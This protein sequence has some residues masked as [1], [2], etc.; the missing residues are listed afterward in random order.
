M[1]FGLLIIVLFLMLPGASNAQS[2]EGTVGYVGTPYATTPDLSFIDDVTRQGWFGDARI[3][4]TNSLSMEGQ[5]SGSYARIEAGRTVT[6][7]DL[8]FGPRL[9]LKDI[10]GVAPYGHLLM[11][12]THRNWVATTT[13]WSVSVGLGGGVV[14]YPKK[15]GQL[16]LDI[17]MDYKKRL[18]FG[19]SP[20]WQDVA[21]RIGVSFR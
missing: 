12:P 19:D 7:H 4:L 16:G 14:I 17:G 15:Q 5:L 11:G 3:L 1:K 21:L 13:G 6:I 9:V 18:Q 20:N 2:F 8:L 10:K